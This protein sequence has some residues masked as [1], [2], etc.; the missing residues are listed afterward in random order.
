MT[1]AWLLQDCLLYIFSTD[2][3]DHGAHTLMVNTEHM[4]MHC[5]EQYCASK[6]CADACAFRELKTFQRARKKH[7]YMAKDSLRNVS[8]TPDPKQNNLRQ[9]CGHS[10]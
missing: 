3:S 8:A 7:C 5:E 9:A 10:M 1:Y 4:S 2:T 6:H